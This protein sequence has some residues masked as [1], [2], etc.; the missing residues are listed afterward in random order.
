MTFVIGLVSGLAIALV[1]PQQRKRANKKVLDLISATVT[2]WTKEVD[3]RQAE[4][5][6]C[7]YLVT[8]DS[9]R[10]LLSR[11]AFEAAPKGYRSAEQMAY[12]N[13]RLSVVT[14]IT[15]AGVAAQHQEAV[16]K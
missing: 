3:T 12:D 14:E 7:V 6:A 15:L 4:T 1:L 11:I 8:Q 9:G 13:G 16:N 10:S 2:M 5:D